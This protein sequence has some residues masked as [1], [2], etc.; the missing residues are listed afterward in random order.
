M[1]KDALDP[2]IHTQVRLRIMTWS[3]AL[4]LLVIVGVALPFL[5]LE[6]GIGYSM[7]PKAAITGR[8]GGRGVR[9]RGAG[10]ASSSPPA[11]S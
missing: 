4:S 5:G 3:M 10:A 1:G 9:R 11:P 6:F 2:V 8:G 7:G